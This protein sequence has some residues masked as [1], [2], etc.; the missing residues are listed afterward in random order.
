MSLILARAEAEKRKPAS[1]MGD[2]SE[3]SKLAWGTLK[4]PRHENGRV[5][6]FGTASVNLFRRRDAFRVASAAEEALHVSDSRVDEK[7][8]VLR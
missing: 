6:G 7:R 8:N 2:R 5:L 4:S 3:S 1:I